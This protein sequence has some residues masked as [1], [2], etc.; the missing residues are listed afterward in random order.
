MLVRQLVFGVIGAVILED[1]SL[2]VLAFQKAFLTEQ[3]DSIGSIEELK[4][5]FKKYFFISL[6]VIN[7]KTER[8][9]SIN[10][11]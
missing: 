2:L 6:L 1:N 10:D 9:D 7:S 3:N 11:V 4:V 8:I 5:S